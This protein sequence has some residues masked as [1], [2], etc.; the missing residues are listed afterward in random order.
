MQR[1]RHTGITPVSRGCLP[2]RCSR[3][4]RVV[5]RYNPDEEL[6][7]KKV[8]QLVEKEGIDQAHARRVVARHKQARICI[9]SRQ[10]LRYDLNHLW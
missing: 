3:N 6:V 8:K 2:L 9:I 1:S 4:R 7:K 10:E 5:A